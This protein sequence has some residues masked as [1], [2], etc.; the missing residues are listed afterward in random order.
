MFHLRPVT[1]PGRA[2]S[3]GC[4]HRRAPFQRAAAD[5]PSHGADDDLAGAAAAG[6][7]L[8]A[9]RP[10]LRLLGSVVPDE[11]AEGPSG[12]HEP[13]G[14]HDDIVQVVPMPVS[15]TVEYFACPEVQVARHPRCLQQ[16]KRWRA[17]RRSA[18]SPGNR[19]R[20]GLLRQSVSTFLRRRSPCFELLYPSGL[21]RSTALSFPTAAMTASL[22]GVLVPGGCVRA[23]RGR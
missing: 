6:R 20:E 2:G 3:A 17:C 16:V 18:R 4:G 13:A 23:S 21:S 9:R 10:A 12:R 15:K 11:V 14:R 8:P 7:D 1:A 19:H 22:R 5:H